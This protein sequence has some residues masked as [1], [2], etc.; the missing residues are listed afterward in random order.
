M[1]GDVFTLFDDDRY[2]AALLRVFNSPQWNHHEARPYLD[3]LVE[4]GYL[5]N[6]AKKWDTQPWWSLTPKGRL[7]TRAF[8]AAYGPEKERF[9][10]ATHGVW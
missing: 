3:G 4:K 2:L 8:A 10:R 9:L 5:K 1:I 7:T 6:T